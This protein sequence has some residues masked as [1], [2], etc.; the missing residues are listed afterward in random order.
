MR[1][2]VLFI[3]TVLLCAPAVAQKQ[4]SLE[5]C[6]NIALQNNTKL[7]TSKNEISSAKEQKKEAFANYIPLVSATAA[8][9]VADKGLVQMNLSPLGIPQTMEMVDDGVLGSVSA[10]LPL[11]TGGQIA[12]GNKLAKVG[13]EVSTLK[14]NISANEVKLNITQYFWNIVMLKEKLNTL[15]IVDNQLKTIEQ[16]VNAAVNAGVANRNDLLQVNLKRNELKSSRIT[17]ENGIA[18]CRNLLSQSMGLGI[19]SIDVAC[20]IAEQ[21]PQSPSNLYASAHDAVQQTSEYQLLQQNVKA[22]KL[23]YKMSVG[24]NLPTVSVGGMYSYNNL[25]NK[26]QNSLIGLATV[27]IPISNWIG[28]SHN[29]K[30]QK[31]EVQNAENNLKDNGELLV[32]NIKNKWN[33]LNEAY[34]QIEISQNSISQ[35]KENLRLHTDY[36]NAGTCTM[37]DLLEAQTMFQ[38]SKDRFVE[39][40]TQYEI[41]KTE[42]LQSIGR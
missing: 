28:G 36:Y 31:I 27:S 30:R 10:M 9:F 8:G 19:D 13:I 23:Q 22:Q 42:Y 16:N 20:P 14:H 33:A 34:K 35:S 4:Y 29:M 5:E 41:R 1:K 39:N 32:I 18:I 11:Y 12:T 7:K 37:S 6:I 38:Q 25:M 15:T 21:M 40:V 17:V 26:S 2:I 3:T 24:K